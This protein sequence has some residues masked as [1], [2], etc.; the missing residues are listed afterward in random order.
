MFCHLT[1]TF[2]LR[3]LISLPEFPFNIPYNFSAFQKN[4]EDKLKGKIWSLKRKANIR[5]GLTVAEMLVLFN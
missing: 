2:A 1:L 4:L 3:I 5:T